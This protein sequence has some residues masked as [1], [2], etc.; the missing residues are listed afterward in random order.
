[1]YITLIGRSSLLSHN[2]PGSSS[3]ICVFH[4]ETFSHCSPSHMFL[5]NVIACHISSPPVTSPLTPITLFASM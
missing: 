5:S 1:M 2:L 3:V 4:S